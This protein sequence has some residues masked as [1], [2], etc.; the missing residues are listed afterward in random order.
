[1][2]I[3]LVKNHVSPSR[4]PGVSSIH[5][6]GWARVETQLLIPVVKGTLEFLA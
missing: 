2:K 5:S 3:V 1:M 4:D 6:Q